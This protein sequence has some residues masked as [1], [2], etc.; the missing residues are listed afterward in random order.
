MLCIN[1]RNGKSWRTSQIRFG[2]KIRSEQSAPIQIQRDIKNRRWGVRSKAAK[3]A[4]AK[5]AVLY[6]ISIPKPIRTPN[7]S[8]ERGSLRSIART[9]HHAQAS[10][11]GGSNA[12]IVSQ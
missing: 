8:Q 5:K 4:K 11:I 7:Q 1:S 12:F 10:Q 6:F 9:M 2:R 3:T